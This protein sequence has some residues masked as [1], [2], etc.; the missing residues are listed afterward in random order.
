MAYK[1]PEL[2]PLLLAERI[3]DMLREEGVSYGIAQTA[4]GVAMSVLPE[5]KFPMPGFADALKGEL[6]QR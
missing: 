2:K 3:I 5:A 4:L 6:A 1:G